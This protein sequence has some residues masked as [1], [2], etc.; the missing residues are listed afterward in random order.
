MGSEEIFKLNVP[1]GK[2]AITW[3]NSYS[4]VMVKSPGAILIFDPVKVSFEECVRANAIIITHEH[5]DHFDPK[6]AKELQQKTR[7]PILTTPFVAASLLN[8]NVK[9]LRVGDSTTIEDIELHALRCDHP[10]NEPLSFIVSTRPLRPLPNKVGGG[11]GLLFP[12][13][14]PVVY[15]PSDS[16][17]FPEMLEV[18]VKYKPNILLY[19]GVSPRGA[20]QIARLVHPKVVV[21][22]YSDAGSEKKFIEAIR[23]E[24]PETKARLIKRFEI[25][26]YP[27]VWM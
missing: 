25:Y 2:L 10:A 1:L 6:L 21:S 8:E 26:Q 20:A 16:E 4:G 17:A 18:A 12:C 11:E 15:H 14:S 23:R 24:A 5:L 7:A 27:E 3:F 19:V 13:P 9:A 22:F